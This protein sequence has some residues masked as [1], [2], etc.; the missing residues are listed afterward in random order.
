MAM[1][2]LGVHISQYLAIAW[3]EIHRMKDSRV[4]YET[5]LYPL[6]ARRF[7][8]AE[9]VNIVQEA[10]LPIAQRSGCFFYPFNSADRWRRLYETHPDL[11][12]KAIAL[13]ENSKHFLTER[14]KDQASHLRT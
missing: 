3:N 11:F 12:D 1:Q 5:N 2:S 7:T 6:I 14:L 13:E 9:C 10:G 8:R 4:D